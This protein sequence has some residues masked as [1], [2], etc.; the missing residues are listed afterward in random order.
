MSYEKDKIDSFITSA[1]VSSAI[2]AALAPYITSASV[3]SAIAGI[4][5]APYVTSNS[6]SAAVTTDLLT[7]RGP[8]SVSATLSAAAVT[9]AGSPVGCVLLGHTSGAAISTIGFSGSWSDFWYLELHVFQAGAASGTPTAQVFTDG[10]GTPILTAATGAATGANTRIDWNAKI[11]GG[12]NQPLKSIALLSTVYTSSQAISS[13]VT[14]TTG[15]V[16]CVRFVM[17]ATSSV[18][19]AALYGWRKT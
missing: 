11:M 7:V 4:N 2:T 10:G 13:T 5:L 6:L 18:A 12:D 15:F 16:N 17:T 3:S 1:S 8:A 9:V 19:Y 14:A